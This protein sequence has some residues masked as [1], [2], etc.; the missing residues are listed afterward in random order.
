MRGLLDN[1]S[2]V[3]GD[4]RQTIPAPAKHIVPLSAK[5]IF[6]NVLYVLS[7][8]VLA[9]RYAIY[10]LAKLFS[11]WLRISTTDWRRPPP[12]KDMLLAIEASAHSGNSFL[13]ACVREDIQHKVVSH[14]HRL[15]SLR[16]CL[17]QGIPIVI[18]V[19][20]PLEACLSKHSRSV[21]RQN[22]NMTISMAAALLV[23]IAYHRY[24]W[25][26]R[27]RLCI[28]MF[29]ELTGDFP[30]A[31][32]RIEAWSDARLVETPNL[33]HRN[34]FRGERCD[35]RLSY[36]SRAL[37][38]SARTLHDR[39]ARAAEIQRFRGVAPPAMCDATPMLLV[40][41]V[42][43]RLLSIGGMVATIVLCIG[44]VLDIVLDRFC[45]KHF[46]TTTFDL[47]NL[48][49]AAFGF[50]LLGWA[51]RWLD[52]SE[53]AVNLLSEE[54][55]LRIEA[56]SLI[57]M[58]AAILLILPGLGCDVAGMAVLLPPL[59]VVLSAMLARSVRATQPGPHFA[60]R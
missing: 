23:W 37:L 51:M 29:P 4:A 33:C 38:K 59:R 27:A 41:N 11:H 35:I 54:Q 13:R 28:I 26:H 25:R 42:V 47:I 9:D 12:L 45:S 39:F 60:N 52:Y 50:V 36:L 14:T 10:R 15:W 30:M 3:A 1:T 21:A 43:G 53:R 24:A 44:V 19:R 56:D 16:R 55:G 34:E 46:G 5:E 40:S 22:Y 57:C 20:D 18:L 7:H 8:V 6:G 31:R 17:R 48:A 49:T 2:I 32:R 58:A